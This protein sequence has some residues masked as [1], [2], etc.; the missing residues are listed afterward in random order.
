MRTDLLDKI[1]GCLIGGAIGDA[2]GAPVEGMYY[3][4]IRARYGR[5]TELMASQVGNTGT[6]YGGTTG[7]RFR[8]LYDGPPAIPGAV[9][10][11]TALAHYLCL[12]IVR[13]GGRITPDD[14]AKVWVTDLNPNRFWVNERIIRRKLRAGMNPWRSGE[15]SIPA[16]CATMAIAPIGI[17]NAANP[18]QAYQDGFNIA[19]VNQSGF[20]QDAAATM[21]AGVAAAFSPGATV[22]TILETMVELSA[23]PVRRALRLTM[24][25]A[26][27]S[28][29]VDE[30]AAKFYN[31]MLDWLWPWPPDEVW[32]KDRHFS[33]SSLELLPAAM[34]ILHLCRGN[35]TQTLIEGASFGRDCDTIARIAGN[36]VGA[37]HGASQIRPDWIQTVEKA[38]EDLFEEVKE[39]QITGFDTMA[40]R[41]YQVLEREKET[42]QQRARKLAEIL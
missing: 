27:E 10:D 24:D 11:D 8:E 9:T 25:L 6:T 15:G 39:D 42:I 20:N 17:V 16:G 35:A 13:K 26:Y 18:D 12:A 14:A 41:L 19:G 7:D 21:A 36:L 37:L 30:F 1:Y 33:G 34:A 22:N 28:R 40:E 29:S 4:D 5:V 32:N 38:N 3:T 23:Y 31:Q 2:L